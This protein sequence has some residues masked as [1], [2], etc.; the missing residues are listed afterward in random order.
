VGYKDI[1]VW[2]SCNVVQIINPICF[3]RKWCRF[4]KIYQI[5]G[6]FLSKNLML[7]IGHLKNWRAICSACPG[8]LPDFGNR[9]KTTCNG[10]LYTPGFFRF[11]FNLVMLGQC[12]RP[13]LR[14]H[15]GKRNGV[16]HGLCL[17]QPPSRRRLCPR[18]LCIL[19]S[20][21]YHY[22]TVPLP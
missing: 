13:A 2:D 5:E 10:V 15:L 12:V 16:L 17:P 11:F 14:N 3:I 22:P 7:K 8:K 18:A 21:D 9:K 6:F 4:L 1:G 19:T 20:L